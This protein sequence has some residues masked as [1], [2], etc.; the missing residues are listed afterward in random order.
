MSPSTL[1]QLAASSNSSGGSLLGLLVPLIAVLLVGYFVF[2]R[3]QR[4]R[5]RQAAQLRTELTPGV[6]V[7]TTAGMFGHVAQ[8]DDDTFLLEVAPGVTVRFLKQA[9]ARVISE[10]AA[11]TGDGEEVQ[12]T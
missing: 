7:M 1:S 8:I 9:V 6:E 12:P 2:V 11:T 10:P 3:P 5:Q 4:N